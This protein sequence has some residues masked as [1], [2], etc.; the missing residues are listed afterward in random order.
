MIEN[1]RLLQKIA[2]AW[3]LGCNDVIMTSIWRHTDILMFYHRNGQHTQFSTLDPSFLMYLRRRLRFLYFRGQQRLPTHF[4]IRKITKFCQNSR[5]WTSADVSNFH[6]VIYLPNVFET[7]LTGN[8][9]SIATKWWVIQV[10]R[11]S[12]SVFTSILVTEVFLPE[13][14]RPATKTLLM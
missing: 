2:L 12:R 4:F 11:T 9:N 3:F 10:N 13:M 5:N 7:C 8:T 6:Y 1:N 14:C